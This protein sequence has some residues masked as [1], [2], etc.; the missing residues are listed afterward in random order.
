M[1]SGIASV[2]VIGVSGGIVGAQ[3]WTW[4]GEVVGEHVISYQNP[5]P[6]ASPL[7]I[8]VSINASNFVGAPLIAFEFRILPKPGFAYGPGEFEAI[9]FDVVADGPNDFAPFVPPS[10]LN[11]PDATFS[12]SS[13]GQLLRF[14][15]APGNPLDEFEL[16]E[17]RFQIERAF[18]TTFFDLQ[19]IPIV[20]AP[21]AFGLLAAAGLVA[22]RRRR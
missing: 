7:E 22:M 10:V 5:P 13:G 21:G 17:F 1:G 8:D 20:P 9:F 16:G 2:L 19:L 12:L 3:T 4:Q 14:D 11:K 6:K 18:T 15:F